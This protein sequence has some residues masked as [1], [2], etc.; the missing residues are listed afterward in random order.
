MESF[1][2]I[3]VT[4]AAPLFQVEPAADVLHLARARR[5]FHESPAG[6]VP[7]PALS[8]AER[9]AMHPDREDVE[10]HY[11]CSGRAG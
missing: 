11:C 6:G 9:S 8:Q 3:N 10:W 7:T 4:G 2:P 1:D 5:V